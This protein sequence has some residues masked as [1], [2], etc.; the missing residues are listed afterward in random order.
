[1]IVAFTAAQLALA[2][3]PL[4]H[5]PLR[6]VPP[7]MGGF[8]QKFF[9]KDGARVA[10]LV[11]GAPDLSLEHVRSVCYSIEGLGRSG[12]IYG[13]SGGRF[14]VVAEGERDDLEA[15]VASVQ[16]A[17]GESATLREAWQ[18]PVGCYEAAFPVVE[19]QAKMGALITMKGQ[20]SS[21]DYISRHVKVEAVFN[22][23]LKLSSARPQPETITLDCTGDSARLKS[24]VR[25]CYNGPP[26]A[27][28][29]EVTVK[30]SGS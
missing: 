13:L 27:R 23:G 14:E 20:A 26:L 3:V 15:L 4:R 29:D 11:N 5:A 12:I 8:E 2:L 28:P 1:M 30:W 16:A 7:T 17:A 22:R 18:A 19:L 6:H 25:W 10:V 24:F 21:L 9:S